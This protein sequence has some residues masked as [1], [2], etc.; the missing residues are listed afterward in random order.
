M[1]KKLFLIYLLIL[2][3]PI[4]L[5]APNNSQSASK[6]GVPIKVNKADFLKYIYNFEKN[7]DQWVY[8][9]KLPCIIDFYADWCGPCRQMK[10]V[11]DNVAKSYSGK[12][13][14]Y[15]VDVEAQ[16]DLAAYFG[17]QSLPTIVFVPPTGKP[18]GIMGF[19]PQD[20]L[21]KIMEEFFNIKP[22]ESKEI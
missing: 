14:I 11:L 16:K 6:L 1:N 7:P 3:L 13:I 9:G 15:K 10:T 21:T 8:E 20:D 5:F 12:V 18:K 19:I 4:F 17:I 2:G 22:I